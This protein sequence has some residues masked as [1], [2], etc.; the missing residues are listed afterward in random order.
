M[1][2]DDDPVTVTYDK[3]TGTGTINRIDVL[4]KYQKAGQANFDTIQVESQ[5]WTLHISVADLHATLSYEEITNKAF[6]LDGH[7]IREDE[8]ITYVVSCPAYPEGGCKDAVCKF[9]EIDDEANA[10]EVA[11]EVRDFTR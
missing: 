3:E 6:T 7:L 9:T 5:S 8:S 1:R 2:G 11:H 4:R 10:L